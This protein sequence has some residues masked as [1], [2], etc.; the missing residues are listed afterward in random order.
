MFLKKDFNFK[1]IE[2]FF[3][4][5][6]I[7][8]VFLFFLLFSFYLIFVLYKYQIIKGAY[9]NEKVL[10]QTK[11]Y[12]LSKVKNRGS[13][14]FQDGESSRVAV[15]IQNF[16]YILAINPKYVKSPLILYKKLSKII[17]LDRDK[18][19]KKASKKNDPYEEV[20]FR[21]SQEDA[22]K[23]K[24]LREKSI[25]LVKESWR[26]YPFGEI[27]AKVIGFVNFENNGDYGLEKY[28]D[29]VLNRKESQFEGNIFFS[30]FAEDKKNNIFGQKVI[31]K[32]GNLISS[33][34]INL[35][36]FVE[37]ELKKIDQKYKSKYSAAIVIKPATGEI[38]TMTDSK[39]FDLN[40]QRRDFR[41]E[42]VEHRFEVGS[43]FKPLVAAIG[44]ESGK[45]TKDFSYNDKGCI[46]FPKKTMCNFDK[47]GRGPRTNLQTI[48][49]QSLNT[50]MIEIERKIGHK[51][52]LE[53]LLNLGLAEETGIDIDGEISSNISNLNN[54]VD[55]DYA[56]A[57]FGQGIS[58][59][60][61]GITRALSSIASDGYM[62]KPHLIKRIEYGDL[63][64]DQEFE[65]EPRK[66]FSPH[67]IKTIKDIMVK[68]A[69]KFAQNKD[70]YNKNYAIAS[71]TG[72]AQ[73]ASPKGGYYKDKYIHTYFGFFPAY[74]KPEDRYAIFLYT[75]EPKGVRYSSQTMTRP[76]YNIVNFM[77]SYFNIKPDR[78]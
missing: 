19:L 23:I 38:L 64:P 40:S 76:F 1:K 60:P 59:T 11:G 65:E 44:L 30:L 74:A 46:K 49:S 21:I 47:K 69:D 36:A 10:A 50:G 37:K 28:Y 7:D 17:D 51:T 78:L 22:E 25:I 33:I 77:I 61:I 41:N 62:V 27:S 66:V 71:K 15:A 8:F 9:Y 14:F 58:F 72:T 67:T 6:M 43:T 5:Y 75:L 70:Y 52:F 63:I 3:S 2:N 73:I 24:A 18:F 31:S 45:I 16:G 29:Q 55:I 53:Y 13:I 48:I 39:N 4:K 35:S 20:A 68:R 34:D 54:G 56:A 32:E 42:F 26:N 12:S 57:S